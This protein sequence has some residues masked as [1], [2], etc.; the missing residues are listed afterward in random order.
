MALNIIARKPRDWSGEAEYILVDR[1]EGHLHRYVVATTTARSLTH[2]E[3]FWGH[4]FADRKLALDAFNR[5]AEYDATDDP[6]T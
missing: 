5:L 6:E 1:G 3:W 4:Y 2:D